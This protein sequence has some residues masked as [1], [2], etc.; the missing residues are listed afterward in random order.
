MNN[1]PKEKRINKPT[2]FLVDHS[3][4]FTGALMS[5]S[6]ISY[7]LKDKAQLVLVLP[8]YSNVQLCSRL[9]FAK[10][11]Y[12]PF[13]KL[14]RSLASLILYFPTL[15]LSSLM[16]FYYMKINNSKTLLVND[17]YI[18]Q[19]A[20]IRLFGFRGK[21]ITWIRINPYN[22]GKVSNFWLWAVQKSSDKVVAV[23][24]Y[25]KQ[26]LKPPLSL[27]A[28]IL[29]ECISPDFE[30]RVC[31]E[32]HRYYSVDLSDLYYTSFIF[33]FIGNY[34]PGKGQEIAVQALAKV[35]KK[36]PHVRLEF[37]GSDM[38]LKKNQDFHQSLKNLAE[39]LGI[40]QSILFGSFITNT[41][42]VLRGKYAA[43]NLSRSESFSMTVLEAS[44]CGLPVIATRCGGPEEIIEDGRTGILIP[45]DD[46]DA[47]A[48]AMIQ[49]C[50]DPRLA[51]QMGRAAKANV[52][53]KFSRDT[54][55][56]QL[57]KLLEI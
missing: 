34:I 46:V 12:L 2:I 39:S 26:K 36:F 32:S 45:I 16:L 56:N 28:Y 9:D 3:C 11:L 24:N 50:S 40:S 55:Q 15:I 49:L 1:L 8:K 21:I 18:M 10:L 19:G 4:D 33:V 22:Y 52:F 57:S 29:Y 51:Q 38:G 17:F 53:S 48:N 6:N 30:N 41:H 44:A 25:I 54:F 20:L 7:I 5:A 42:Q 35:I 31:E 43:L 37:Y 13:P 23:S 14:N 47:C 27:T